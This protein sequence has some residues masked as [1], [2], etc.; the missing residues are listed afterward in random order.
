MI[1]EESTYQMHVAK[2]PALLEAYAGRGL[3]ILRRVLG[4]ENFVGMWS[5][6]VGGDIDEVIQTWRF[7][8]EADRRARREALKSDP[9]WLDFAGRF[10]G[11]IKTRAMRCPGAGAVHRHRAV[12]GTNVDILTI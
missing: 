6:D 11:L 1:I 5:V 10:G 2:A 3:D 12:L 7:V 8:D 9:D 4:E